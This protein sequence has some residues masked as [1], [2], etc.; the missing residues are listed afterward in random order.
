MMTEGGGKEGSREE[1]S[2]LIIS[3]QWTHK[4]QSPLEFQIS[5]AGVFRP[6]SGSFCLFV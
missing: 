4:N 2:R 3:Y 1:P 6:T 5:M